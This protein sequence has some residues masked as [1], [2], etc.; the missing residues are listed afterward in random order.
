VA[1]L[2]T[3]DDANEL[4]QR[5]LKTLSVVNKLRLDNIQFNSYE[6]KT[7]TTPPQA[8]PPL[9]LDTPAEE[10]SK[11]APR[12]R[13]DGGTNFGSQSFAYSIPEELRRAARI[14]AESAPPAKPEGNHE[15]IAAQARKK[16][17]L[18]TNDT[19]APHQKLRQSNGLFEFAPG[20]DE[21]GV[22]I[23]STGNV[24]GLLKNSEAVTGSGSGESLSKRQASSSSS[25]WMVTMQQRGKSPFA[26]DGYKVIEL[27]YL[28]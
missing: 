14:V 12:K 13:A 18:K 3:V 8:A 10:L 6:Y 22:S 21:R 25:Y 23:P 17:A 19:N 4:V 16:Y 7:S 27:R 5:A 11:K 24:T 1:T 20:W 28:L 9:D 15:S 2:E 26:P